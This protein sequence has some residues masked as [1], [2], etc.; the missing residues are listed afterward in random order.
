MVGFQIFIE[1]YDFYEREY[2]FKPLF[3]KN[4]TKA[5]HDAYLLMYMFMKYVHKYLGTI[6]C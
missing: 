6:C 3:K 4:F 2:D 1:L 5:A